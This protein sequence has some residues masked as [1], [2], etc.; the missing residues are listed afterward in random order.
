[1]S[2]YFNP[3]EV[4]EKILERGEDTI[5]KELH[6]YNKPAQNFYYQVIQE[7]RAER[8]EEERLEPQRTANQLAK[9]TVTTARVAIV[10]S[11]IACIISSVATIYAASLSG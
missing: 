8:Q 2:N 7:I 6:T 4:R 10:F 11:I 9:K 5:L 3:H 1:M